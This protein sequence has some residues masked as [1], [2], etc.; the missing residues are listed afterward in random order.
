MCVYVCVCMNVCV[1]KNGRESGTDLNQKKG[2]P[3]KKN[4]PE[5]AKKKR[6]KSSDKLF[7][8]LKK[9]LNLIEE[10]M[11]IISYLSSNFR[12]GLAQYIL[13]QEALILNLSARILVSEISEDLY[14]FAEII[15]SMT[16]KIS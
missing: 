1:W 13:K 4:F 3:R 5:I 8:N 7:F 2:G 14:L 9:L 11:K 10:N 6:F 12:Y 16:K 15:S